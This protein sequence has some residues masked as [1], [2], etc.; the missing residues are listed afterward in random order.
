VNHAART[1]VAVDIGGTKTSAALVGPSG[2]VG[3]VTVRPTPAAEGAA[4]VVATVVGLVRELATHDTV[5]VG[6]GAAG[7]VD[8]A[9]GTIVAAT[10]HI[11]DWA[12]TPLGGLVTEA[13]GRPTAVVNDVHAHAL[14]EAVGGAGRGRVSFLLVAAGTGL[15]GAF[16]LGGRVVTGSRGAAGHLGH[17]PC[18]EA[19]G[20]PCACGGVGHLECVASGG[21]VRA[22]SRTRG[23][24]AALD[25]SA[26]A[27]GAAVGGWVNTLDPEAV[28]LT[29]GLTGAGEAWWHTVRAAAEGTMVPATRACPIRPAELGARAAL[30][31]AASLVLDAGPGTVGA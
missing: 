2:R 23:T 29:G 1:A 24:A 21:G 18:P 20:L 9:T 13:T 22:L 19:T 10:D 30:V 11:A 17:V 6:I 25:V 14:G 27:L 26:R 7:V 8:A 28:L 31:G 4:A 15:G 5:G 12:G 3:P 16:V